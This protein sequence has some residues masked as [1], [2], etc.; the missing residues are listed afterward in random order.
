MTSL[1]TPMLE[2][3]GLSARYGKVAALN[4]ANLSVSAGSI[5]TVIGANGAGKSTLLNAIMGSLPH[6]GASLWHIIP[7]K[8]CRDGR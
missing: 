1:V 3:S 2:V 4:N 6:T 8:M 5:V 7:T